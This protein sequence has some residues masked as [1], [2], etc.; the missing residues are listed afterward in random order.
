[1]YGHK[2]LRT[3]SYPI[4]TV[5][6][7][8]VLRDLDILEYAEEFVPDVIIAD[9]MDL[10]KSEDSRLAGRDAINET[11]KTAKSLAQNRKILWATG[12]QS[13]R[14]S[15][16]AKTVKQGHTGEDIRKLAHVDIMS[17]LNQTSWE[18]RK[19]MMRFGIL[20]HRHK[21]FD[22]FSQIQVLQQLEL[23]QPYLEGFN[24]YGEE[25]DED[26]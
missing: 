9:Y 8:D 3:I 11:W 24:Y 2:N 17:V 1:M 20:V 25:E 14:Q 5:S 18:K 22:D 4:N 26:E 6:I 19:K 15:I 21:Y 23:G 10:F 12:T 7:S 16:D 13:N